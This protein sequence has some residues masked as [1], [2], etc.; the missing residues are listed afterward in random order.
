[1]HGLSRAVVPEAPLCVLV[2]CV[3]VE[4]DKDAAQTLKSNVWRFARAPFPG[5]RGGGFAAD[6]ALAAAWAR[7]RL[8]PPVLQVRCMKVEAFRELCLA[9]GGPPGPGGPPAPASSAGSPL[10]A[11]C[12]ERPPGGVMAVFVAGAPCQGCARA[13][14]PSTP[15]GEF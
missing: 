10:P 1:M 8:P 4:L 7:D 12:F 14:A 15:A 2:P 11:A 9:Q 3:A 13:R 5:R 6:P